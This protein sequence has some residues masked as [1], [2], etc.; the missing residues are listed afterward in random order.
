MSR[1]LIVDDDAEIG[2]LSEALLQIAGHTTAVAADGAEGYLKL[3]DFRPDVVLL[4]VEM[5][6]LDGPGMMK[7]M[8]VEDCGRE[9]I[10]VVLVSGVAE[11]AQLAAQVGTPYFLEKPVSGDQLQSVVSR[12]LEERRPPRPSLG[13]VRQ[14]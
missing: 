11:L 5:P 8:L 1:V 4:D 3:T 9:N 10:P 13:E 12:A 2:W 7:R 6:V 14:P